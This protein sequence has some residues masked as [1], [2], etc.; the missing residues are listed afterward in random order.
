MKEIDGTEPLTMGH[1]YMR[2]ELPDVIERTFRTLEAAWH[3][4]NKEDDLTFEEFVEELGQLISAGTYTDDDLFETMV[5]YLHL[6][7]RNSPTVPLEHGIAL[8][9]LARRHFDDNKHENAW[10][11]IAGAAYYAGYTFALQDN[12][13]RLREIHEKNKQRGIAGGNGK[14]KKLTDAH[15]HTAKLLGSPPG[16]GWRSMDA[17][18]EA[19]EKDLNKHMA[20]QD[21]KRRPYAI[22]TI[23]GWIQNNPS[24]KDVYKANK[25]VKRV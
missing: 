19:I 1:D 15:E 11:L 22:G 20:E 7:R 14:A 2:R 10:P 21:P 17:A 6:T 16:E 23:A 4:T 9:I 25:R 3:E 13:P 24:V 12:G 8:A 5:P 18:A